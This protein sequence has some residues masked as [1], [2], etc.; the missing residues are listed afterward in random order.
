MYYKHKYF[1]FKLEIKNTGLVHSPSF[2]HI[3]VRT[4]ILQF[5]SVKDGKTKP[6]M[7]VWMDTLLHMAP[8]PSC[9]NFLTSYQ[10]TF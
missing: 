4:N 10:Y 7:Q 9:Q 8:L 2:I 6:F 5:F 3:I 1:L